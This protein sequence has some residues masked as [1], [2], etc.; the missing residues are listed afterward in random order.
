[1]SPEPDKAKTEYVS[2]ALFVYTTETEALTH[3]FLENAQGTVVRPVAIEE[4]MEILPGPDF[5]TAGIIYGNKGIVDA[6]KTG[7]GIMRIRA[8]GLSAT[9][10]AVTPISC[11]RRAWAIMRLGS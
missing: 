7:R 2:S 8:R 5:P 6:Y 11:K 10:M 4:L 1:V 9:L 3:T